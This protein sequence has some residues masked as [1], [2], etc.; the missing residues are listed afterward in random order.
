KQE[1]FVTW[2][3]PLALLEG[4]HTLAPSVIA[5]DGNRVVGYALT[6]PLA[7]RSFHREM[8]LFLQ[9]M[10]KVQYRDKPLLDYSF[11]GMGQICIDK[12][13]RGQGLFTGLYEKHKELYSSQH[14]FIITDIATSNPRSL[15]AHQ[16]QGF[17]PIHKFTDSH[18]EW[19][20]VIWDWR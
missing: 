16:K 10:E 14:D 3:Y 20:V 7:S 9:A 17:I 11:Y 8:D 4:M 15:K 13:Y 2:L 1:G 18:G 6:T 12:D 19:V 5:K